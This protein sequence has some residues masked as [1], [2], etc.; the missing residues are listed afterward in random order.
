MMM[1]GCSAPDSLPCTID[2][3]QDSSVDS[4]SM[5]VFY[6]IVIVQILK[7][8]FAAW[9]SSEQSVSSLGICKIQRSLALLC[10]EHRNISKISVPTAIVLVFGSDQQ[11][12]PFYH[13]AVSSLDLHFSC[14]MMRTPRSASSQTGRP[15]CSV[16][17]QYHMNCCES[18]SW[19][20]AALNDGY[21][22]LMYFWKGRKRVTHRVKSFP[23]DL[24]Q[25]VKASW[26]GDL[27]Q[28]Y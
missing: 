3:V 11:S 28:C 24:N 27:L 9:C 16:T 2:G 18:T 8:L 21:V 19:L 12:T 13:V 5:R 14:V 6:V 17:L 10:G 22:W 25:C 20:L 26:N 23:G 7:S 15:H 1:L 4:S